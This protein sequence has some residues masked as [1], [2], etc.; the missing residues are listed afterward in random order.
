MYYWISIPSEKPLYNNRDQAKA[1][2]LALSNSCQKMGGALLDYSLEPFLCRFLAMLPQKKEALPWKGK[3]VTIQRLSGKQD[4]L[5]AYATLSEGLPGNGKYYEL[6]GTFEAFHKSDCYCLFGK[7]SRL[8]DLPSFREILDA[9]KN[10]KSSLDEKTLPEGYP[11]AVF[12]F[13]L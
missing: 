4:L 13:S 6:C 9:K 8:N 10:K 12:A 7:V 3:P 5:T 2:L 11:T 1:H